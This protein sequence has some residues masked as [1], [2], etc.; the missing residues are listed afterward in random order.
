MRTIAIDSLKIGL[1]V[2]EY[3][4]TQVCN[5]P[6]RVNLRSL[7]FDLWHYRLRHISYNKLYILQKMYPFIIV[8]DSK[9]PC[10]YY[11]FTKPKRLSYD[12]SHAKPLHNFD[13]V[14]IDI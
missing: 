8:L 3:Q 14:L 2:L 9:S 7:V 12:A 4:A 5:S 6:S 10:E 13:S 1:Y 11:H